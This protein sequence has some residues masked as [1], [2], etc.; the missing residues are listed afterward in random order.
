MTIT[1][2][3]QSPNIL[4]G[5]KK[6]GFGAGR[7]NGFGGKVEEGESIEDT[8]RREIFEEAG[9]HVGTLDKRG[10]LNFT[11]EHNDDH[12]E[13]HVFNTKDFEGEI[14]E[15]EEMRPQ[16]FKV[17]EIPFTEMWK[18]DTIW[19]PLF[20]EGKHFTGS[21]HFDESHTVLMHGLQENAQL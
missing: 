14:T 12:I 3:Y 17:S 15:S 21:F 16:W 18:S 7:W 13:A 19:L 8:A 9:I 20:L 5:M 2:L 4:L 1:F 6:R 11:F 10:I